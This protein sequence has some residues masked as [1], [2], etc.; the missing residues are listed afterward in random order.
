MSIEVEDN[1]HV[2]YQ[3]GPN[4]FSI[5]TCPFTPLSPKLSWELKFLPQQHNLIYSNIFRNITWTQSNKIYWGK[6][7]LQL[8]QNIN[9]LCKIKQGWTVEAAMRFLIRDIHHI[10]CEL[11]FIFV[12]FIVWFFQYIFLIRY[13]YLINLLP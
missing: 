4:H 10:R 5:E 13:D 2:S 9:F 7:I 3:H 1:F 8:N 12:C 11:A 6:W